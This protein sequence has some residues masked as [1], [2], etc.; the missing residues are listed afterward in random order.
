MIRKLPFSSFSNKKIW[1]IDNIYNIKLLFSFVL[2]KY[3]MQLQV[4]IH[5]EILI[6]D[7]PKRKMTWLSMIKMDSGDNWRKFCIWGP[8]VC[9]WF[10]SLASVYPSQYIWIQTSWVE[11]QAL[12][13][14]SCTNLS[15]LPKLLEM[16]H[17]NI[18]IYA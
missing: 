18:N 11:I 12:P 5:E 9:L 16:Q 15:K 17:E 6:L 2:L 8:L 14:T 10:R 1:K 3:M 7:D 4:A 13:F